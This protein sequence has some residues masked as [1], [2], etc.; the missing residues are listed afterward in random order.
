MAL[1]DENELMGG[2]GAAA[3]F[4]DSFPDAALE[5]TA[6][7]DPYAG[8]VDYFGFDEREKWFFPDGKQ[9]IEF[10]KL[11]EGDRAKYLKA[12]RSDVHLNQ[13][14]QEARLSFDQSRDRK[15][16]L[17]AAI[18]DWHIV[19]IVGTGADKKVFLIPFNNNKTVG[20][21]LSKWIDAANPA[22]L[23]NLEKA[24]RKCNPWLLNEMTVEDIDKEI[25]D[26]HELRAVAEKREAEEKN[27]YTR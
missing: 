27:S 16:L 10:K 22:L 18:T 17:L 13:K 5:I 12:T 25:A 9:W 2:A 7:S 4:G 19:R 11:T 14:T 23:G 1:H 20:G 15:E 8:Y 24:I 26:L 6:S 21:E 3:S